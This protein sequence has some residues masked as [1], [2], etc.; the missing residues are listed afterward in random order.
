MDALLPGV[1]PSGFTLMRVRLND[2]GVDD[3]VP[4]GFNVYGEVEDYTVEVLDWVC[5]DA[6]GNGTF[7]YA[8]VTYLVDM[9]FAS[10]AV[11]VPWQAGDA[12]ADGF[13]NLADIVFLAEALNGGAAP[14]C[15]P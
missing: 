5:G 6:D 8:D 13:V 2:G 7:E 10:G 14:I 11:P 1:G 15:L 3:P 4:C 9:Y 12:N